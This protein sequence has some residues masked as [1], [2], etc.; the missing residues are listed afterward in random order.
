MAHEEF[1][2][3]VNHVVPAL[4]KCQRNIPIVADNEE[5]IC[6][7]I[8]Q[9]L[10]RLTR[11]R[12]WNHTI[13]AAKAWLRKHGASG[14]EIPIYVSHLRELFCQPSEEA[15][16]EKLNAVESNW[17][18]AF[19]DYHRTEIHPKSI[20]DWTQMKWIMYARGS[21]TCVR[22]LAVRARDSLNHLL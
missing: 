20:S 5:G 3:H 8:N 17:S 16:L 13:N 2:K 6:K 12:C 1:M 11:L 10:P 7:A 4:S 22:G 19:V 14:S 21:L 18:R 15:Y 9:H